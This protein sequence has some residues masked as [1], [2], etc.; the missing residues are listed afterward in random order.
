E[1]FGAAINLLNDA[2]PT[3]DPNAFTEQGKLLDG[4]ES[5]RKRTPGHDWCIIQLGLPGRVR[6]IEVDT[7]FFTGNHAPRFSLQ[8]ASLDPSLPELQRLA[9]HWSRERVGTAAGDDELTLV[10]AL[11]PDE[12]RELVPVT[13]LQPGYAD[14]SRQFFPVTD[15]T[16]GNGGNG[17]NGA[18]SSSGGGRVTHVRLNMF[19]DGGIARLRVYGEV[20]RD[21]ASVAAREVLDLAAVENGGIAVGCSDKHF[22]EPKNMIKAGRGVNMGDGWETARHAHR[23]PVLR[24]GTDGLLQYPAGQ[25]SDNAVLK[26]GTAG[27]V[28]RLVVDTMHF[29]GNFPESAAVD[30]CYTPGALPEAFQDKEGGKGMPWRPLLRRT[31]MGPDREH[32]F[33]LGRGELEDCGAITHLRLT[34]SPDGGV[35]RLRAFGVKA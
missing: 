34:I 5:R 14:S 8:A 19:P 15:E 31:R 28:Q 6:G 18:G 2:E 17:G 16:A 27:V 20:E 13:P 22:G 10:A 26:L 21:W 7:A 29:K 30:G 4:W 3:F 24:L 9:H 1:W 32:T 11:R 33:E 12:W 35:M 23:P 25:G